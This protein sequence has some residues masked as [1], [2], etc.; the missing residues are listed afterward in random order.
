MMRKLL[1]CV[2]LASS[3]TGCRILSPRPDPVGACPDLG[4]V[5]EA[6]R[7]QPLPSG[8]QLP[9][10]AT[11]IV[12]GMCP[13]T[14]AYLAA[15]VDTRTRAFKYMV[16][17]G[18]VTRETF[19]ANAYRA[20]VPVVLYT[21]PTRATGTPGAPPGASVAQGAVAT[22]PPPPDPTFDPCADIPNIGEEPPKDPEDTGGASP[23]PPQEFVDLAWR[24]ATAV[25]NASDPA[26][27]STTSTPR[28]DVPR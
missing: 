4:P 5:P 11:Q 7:V 16:Y 20:G 6:P 28:T 3:L 24:S 21:S 9:Q 26:A 2:L 1:L 10:G 8:G 17:G 22:P 19:L 13:T 25:D 12:V 14:G 18:R 15:G 27:A 23:H